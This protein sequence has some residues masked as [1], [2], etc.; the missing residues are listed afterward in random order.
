MQLHTNALNKLSK[1]NVFHKFRN[2]FDCILKLKNVVLIPRDL[3][4]FSHTRFN[5]DHV[6]RKRKH[7]ADSL[8]SRKN[9]SGIR[10]HTY[11]DMNVLVVSLTLVV[12]FE[13]V[14]LWIRVFCLENGDF[15]R[16]ANTVHRTSRSSW[17]Q[18]SNVGD[19]NNNSDEH[20][21][22]FVT[23]HTCTIRIIKY[24]IFMM[25]F[26]TIKLSNEINNILYLI[27]NLL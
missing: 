16:P 19:N 22:L 26:R 27:Y 10:M 8:L 24:C 17:R 21:L 3:S 4:I 25:L 11:I 7:V 15:R 13:M 12:R 1:L 14:M 2:Y 23:I 20:L 9:E 6:T 18:C 5:L